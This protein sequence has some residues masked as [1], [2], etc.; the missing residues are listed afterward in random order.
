M[1]ILVE[2]MSLSKGSLLFTTFRFVVLHV[3]VVRSRLSMF[4]LHVVFII[5]KNNNTTKMHANIPPSHCFSY[6]EY[7]ASWKDFVQGTSFVKA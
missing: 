7:I 2:G 4:V 6:N 3:V 5:N 1:F